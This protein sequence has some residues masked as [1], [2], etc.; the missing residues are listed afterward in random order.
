MGYT[1]IGT[2]GDIYTAQGVS[3]GPNF[4]TPSASILTINS[5]SPIA[6]NFDIT[7]VNLEITN[8]AGAVDLED[9]RFTTQYVVDPSAVTGQK[10]TF[11]TVQAAVTAANAAG[12]G[13]V[14]I[15]AGTY[16]ENVNV[17]SDVTI[18]SYAGTTATSTSSQTTIIGSLVFNNANN[19]NVSNIVVVANGST[20]PI[21]FTGTT[22]SFIQLTNV[23][24]QASSSVVV[25]CSNNAAVIDFLDSYVFQDGAFAQVDISA[26]F[27]EF[28]TCYVGASD[29]VS[30]SQVPSIISGT[31]VLFLTQGSFGGGIQT[32]GTGSATG[33]YA[34]ITSGTIALDSQSTRPSDFIYSTFISGGTSSAINIG[35]GSSVSSSFGSGFS[36]SGSN[37][38]SGTGTFSYDIFS[39][40]NGSNSSID[41]GL[42]VVLDVVRPFATTTTRGL[43]Y[44]NPADFTVASDGQV[45]SISSSNFTWNT[46]AVNVAAMTVNNGYFCISAG[47]ALTI[48]LPTVSVL[49]NTVRVSLKG[50]TS[51]QITQPNAGSQII[52]G[53]SSTTVGTGGSLMSTAQGDSIELVALTTNGVWVAESY[54]GNITVI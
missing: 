23:S 49:G 41:P 14:F 29:A 1:G 45:S 15:R 7:S 17:P 47:G 22:T 28:D 25:S 9:L 31:G 53:S 21:Q 54:V 4:R 43:A 42:T 48:G 18:T 52:L 8:S 39:F 3:T 36:N 6:N 44:F 26:G 33:Q 30:P 46:T 27:V 5:E 34:Q 11:T 40:L 50:A 38:I 13:N 32:T 10:A 19:V 37:A 20:I 51:W 12:G 35:A 2:T 24:V 16:V